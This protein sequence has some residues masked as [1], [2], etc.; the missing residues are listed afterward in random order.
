MEKRG[1][2]KCIR[3]GTATKTLVGNMRDAARKSVVVIQNLNR[4]PRD[5]TFFFETGNGSLTPHT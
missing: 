1:S 5:K 2:D 3:D 4:L